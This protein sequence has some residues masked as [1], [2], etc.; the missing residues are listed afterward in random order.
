[1]PITST[2]VGSAHSPTPVPGPDR[3]DN[4][5]IC[6]RRTCPSL[7]TSSQN[8]VSALRCPRH[9]RKDGIASRDSDSSGA[10]SAPSLLDRTAPFRSEPA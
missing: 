5:A 3:A 10:I 7:V 9:P 2:S 8:D 1:M 4:V 6:C